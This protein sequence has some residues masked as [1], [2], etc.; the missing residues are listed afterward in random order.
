M[1]MLYHF[2]IVIGFST[3]GVIAW[4]G[5]ADSRRGGNTET[6]GP[7]VETGDY[8]FWGDYL[9]TPI[10]EMTPK[11]WRTIDDIIDG[12]DWSLPPDIQPRPSW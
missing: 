3:S 2:M 5:N 6:I 10:E 11:V 8:P 7:V 9:K 4:A 12:W 1:S